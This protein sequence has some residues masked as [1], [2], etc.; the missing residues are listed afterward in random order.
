MLNPQLQQ[1]R[2]VPHIVTST[3]HGSYDK[4]EQSYG[5][6]TL[7]MG[8]GNLIVA[9]RATLQRWGNLSF[10]KVFKPLAEVM[11]G[12]ELLYDGNDKRKKPPAARIPLDGRSTIINAHNGQIVS[13]PQDLFIIAAVAHLAEWPVFDFRG[14]GGFYWDFKKDW[15][16]VLLKLNPH[17][18]AA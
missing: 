12:V 17:R 6:Q 15:G 11:S 1:E 13:I 9:T 5:L 4:I 7:L 8:N 18:Q 3:E 10:P 16:E 14:W 2:G